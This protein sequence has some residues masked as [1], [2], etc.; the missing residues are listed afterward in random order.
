MYRLGSGLG[1][2]LVLVL[3]FCAYNG[4]VYSQGIPKQDDSYLS[5]TIRLYNHHDAQLSDCSLPT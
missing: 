5:F 3:R 4:G 1:L 2:V